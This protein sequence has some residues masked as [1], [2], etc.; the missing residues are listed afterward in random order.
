[1]PEL[2]E[3]ETIRED[4]APLILGRVIERVVICPDPKGARLLRRYPSERK[5]IRRLRGKKIVSLKRRGKY[6]LFGLDSGDILII[7]LGMSGR[8]L[9]AQAGDGTPAYARCFFQLSGC[10]RLYFIDP[11]KFGEAYLFSESRKDTSMNPFRLGPEPLGPNFTSKRLRDI[12]SR[13]KSPIKS[14]LLN[15]SNLAGLGNIYTD[16]ALFRA[17]VHPLRIGS[18][19]S[20]KEAGALHRAIRGVLKEAI[21]HRG[22]TATDGRYRDGKG[23]SGKF[24]FRLKVYQRRGEPCSCC[25]AKIRSVTIGGRTAHFCPRCQK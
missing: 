24:Q 2:P 19:L 13:R 20:P 21:G 23:R 22:T 8:L 7:H 11:R 25:G 5:F 17:R 16:E 14:I 3:V 1:M 12:L 6:L 18:T 9:L 4:L 15:Q 10:D